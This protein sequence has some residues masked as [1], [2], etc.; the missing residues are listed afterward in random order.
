[1][2]AKPVIFLSGKITGDPNYKAKFNDAQR[3]LESKGRVV[4]NPAWMPA[5]LFNDD[6]MRMCLAMIDTADLVVFLPDWEGSPGARLE[7]QYCDYTLKAYC[8]L[9]LA[10]AEWEEIDK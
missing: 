3:R 1:M 9:D 5:G 4:L 8:N 6:Y 7:K 10:L 2:H